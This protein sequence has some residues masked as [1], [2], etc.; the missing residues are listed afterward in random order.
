MAAR[1]GYPVALHAEH[2]AHVGEEHYLVVGVAAEQV[3]NK[4][5][6]PGGLAGYAPAAPVLGL[7]G[8]HAGALCEAEVGKGHRHLLGLY[9]VVQLYILCYLGYLG[10]SGVGVFAADLQYLLPN[11]AQQ[12]VFVRKDAFVIGDGLHKAV[13][14]R[15]YLVVLQPCKAA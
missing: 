13:P 7:I 5:L 1:L 3:L 6:L 11:Y 10:P 14:L 15:L 9:Y 12:L 8:I 4:I 2:P